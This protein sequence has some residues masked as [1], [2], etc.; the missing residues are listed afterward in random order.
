M[1]DSSHIGSITR[2]ISPET[3]SSVLA[4]L[5][6]SSPK[7]ENVIAPS[8]ISSTTA[9]TLPYIITPNASR[10]KTSST[11]TSGTMNSKRLI[12]M[13]ARKSLRRIGVARNRLSSLRMRMSTVTKPTPHSPPPIRLMPSKPG[14]EKV[15][16]AARPAR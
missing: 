11:S 7:P 1:P 2:F 3:A 16:I 14:H 9:A 8:K 13:P 15:D 5:A 10:A 4:R 12:M 6:T